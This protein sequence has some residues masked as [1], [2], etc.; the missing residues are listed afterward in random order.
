MGVVMAKAGVGKTACLIH[1]AMHKLLQNEKLIHI[2]LDTPPDK[3]T[4]YY[5]VIFSELVKALD[6]K[7]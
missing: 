3:V 5:R 7:K 6:I 2:S 4:S 1:I